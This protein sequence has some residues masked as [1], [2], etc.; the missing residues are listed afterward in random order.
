MPVCIFCI[1]FWYIHKYLKV[2]LS[3]LTNLLIFMFYLYFV[4]L[5]CPIFLQCINVF[6]KFQLIKKLYD[7]YNKFKS[8]LFILKDLYPGNDVFGIKQKVGDF[9]NKEIIFEHP[10]LKNK[11]SSSFAGDFYN[12][13]FTFF[14]INFILCII[15][16]IITSHLTFRRTR[17]NFSSDN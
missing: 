8:L 12:F 17:R 2:Y 4:K 15:I 1:S 11:C 13:K 6:K 16:R 5:N 9:P 3:V 10:T 7:I 14:N